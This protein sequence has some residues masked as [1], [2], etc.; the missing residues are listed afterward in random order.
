MRIVWACQGLWQTPRRMI[1]AHT[2]MSRSTD[3][4]CKSA[5]DICAAHNTLKRSARCRCRHL[6]IVRSF[7]R[8]LPNM[9]VTYIAER[10]ESAL[11]VDVNGGLPDNLPDHRILYQRHSVYEGNPAPHWLPAALQSK[12]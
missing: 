3:F 5:R 8:D 10:R 11:E 9:R 1:P 12:L 6:Q 7:H 4:M 2:H